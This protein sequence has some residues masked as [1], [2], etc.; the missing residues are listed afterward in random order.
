MAVL[1][2]GRSL[3]LAVVVAVAEAGCAN[4][5]NPEAGLPVPKDPGTVIARV[6]DQ[7][8][9]PMRDVTVMVR[10]IPNEVGTFYSVGHGT[11]ASGVMI[12]HN[13]PAGHRRV[14]VMPPTGFAAAP[15]G[16]VKEVDVVKDA[17]VTVVFG[18]VRK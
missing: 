18:L 3:A 9:A 5:L 12:I 8:G 10:D 4:P 7:D 11:D 2:A 14:E 16:A 17:T 6:S 15:D 1:S 13:I